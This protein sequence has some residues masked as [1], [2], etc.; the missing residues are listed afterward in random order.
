[1]AGLVEDGI[2]VDLNDRLSHPARHLRE[3]GRRIAH[4]IGLPSL[5]FATGKHRHKVLA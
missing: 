3:G 2:K 1:V 4:G 5:V